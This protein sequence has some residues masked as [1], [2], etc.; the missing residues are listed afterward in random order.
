MRA[1]TGEWPA[2]PYRQ[3][4]TGESHAPC[5]CRHHAPACSARHRK[6]CTCVALQGH[7]AHHSGRLLFLEASTPVAQHRVLALIRPLMLGCGP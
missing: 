3:A 4:H 7:T 5:P 6:A 2:T 1:D